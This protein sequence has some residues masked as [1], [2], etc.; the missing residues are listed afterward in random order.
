MTG[1]SAKRRRSL[2]WSKR[3]VLLALL[4]AVVVVDVLVAA[5]RPI[6]GWALVITFCPL[7]TWFMLKW[8]GRI[9]KR[10]IADSTTSSPASETADVPANGLP[11]DATLEAVDKQSRAR[12]REVNVLGAPGKRALARVERHVVVYGW[13]R[14]SR[15]PLA[16]KW[17]LTRAGTP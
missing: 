13:F 17:D 6:V 2:A 11:L 7:H 5:A 4:I 10:E 1:P 15:H 14:P 16:S 9:E 12:A 3:A 8:T